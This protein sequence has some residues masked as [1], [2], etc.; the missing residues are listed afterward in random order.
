MFITLRCVAVVLLGTI[1]LGV[2]VRWLLGR[3][4]P[5]DEDGWVE[6]PF[7]GIAA[8]VLSLQTLVYHQVPIASS[9]PWVWAVAAL[10]WLLLWRRGQFGDCWRRCPWPLFAAALAVF[11]VHALGLLILGAHSYVGRGWPDQFNYTTIAEYLNHWDFSLPRAQIGQRPYLF[12]GFELRSDQ[13]GQSLLHGFYAVSAGASTKTLFEPSILLMPPLLVLAVYALGRRLG[14]SRG[15]AVGCGLAAALLPGVTLLHL[16]GFFSHALLLP[17]LLCC[18]AVLEGHETGGDWTAAARAAVLLAAAVSIYTELLPVLLAA[19][20]L[21]LVVALWQRPLRRQSLVAYSL[22]ALAPFL[23]NPWFVPFI[24]RIL[25]R[26]DRQ[27]LADVYPWAL[28]TEGIERLW[29]GDLVSAL[30]HRLELGLRPAA[31][32]LLVLACYGTLR[33]GLAR[34]AAPSRDAAAAPGPS[35]AL[36]VNL[37]F[38]LALPFLVIAK[39]ANHPYQF[40]KLLLTASPLLVLGLALLGR[41]ATPGA[42]P[43]EASPTPPRLVMLRLAPGVLLGGLTV[44]GGAATAHMVL[45]TTTPHAEDRFWGRV[46]LGPPEQQLADFLEALHGRNIAYS[47]TDSVSGT[48]FYFNSWISYFAR[49]NR[50]WLAN[51][52]FNDGD[53]LTVYPRLRHLA[54]L[55]H[56]PPDVLFLSRRGSV[57]LQPPGGF[58]RQEALWQNR[59]YVLWTPR[60]ADVAMITNI[61]APYGLEPSDGTF[62]WMG[63]GEVAVDVLAPRPGRVRLSA[64]FRLG[65]SL[66]GR[67][68]R[69]VRVQA[70]GVPAEDVVIDETAEGFR[71]PVQQGVNRIRLRVLEKATV[72]CLPSGDTR[73]LL[74]GVDGLAAAL[75]PEPAGDSGAGPG[76]ASPPAPG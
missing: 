73:G 13:I 20:L 44:V 64:H 22:I 7:L 9:A 10:L 62:F 53:D 52:N 49:R 12:K 14:F 59:H 1:A 25:R 28:R 54:D 38:L 6:A 29:F 31:L 41:R 15:Y 3:C 61:A 67:S 46:L 34:L 56:L 48:G 27:V 5:L 70:E 19:P 30:P 66:P 63:Q 60:T 17:L 21:F 18:L 33:Y 69:T 47:G 65:P 51:P 35:K 4:R 50:L 68:T 55:S 57:L 72:R 40:Y 24:P 75:E 16:E 36:V 45:R 74:L 58:A 32:A 42:L 71:V 8:I 76:G 39:D 2:P 23:L 26:V 37:V 43:G 11:L